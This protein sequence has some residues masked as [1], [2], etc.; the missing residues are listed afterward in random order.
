MISTAGDAALAV[1]ARD[2]AL[3][4][5][6]LQVER[7]VHQ[8]LRAALFGEEVDDAV[9]RLVGAVGVQR[10]E[11]QVAGFGERDRV[12]PSSRGR[13]SR[14]SGSRRAPGA[15]CSSAP[16]SQLSVSTPTSRCVMM[17]F[18]CVVHELDRV[19]DRDDVA[20]A[21]SR[22]GSR[23]S[24]RARSTCPSRWR[25]RRSRG[26]AWSSTTS[27]STGGRPQVVERRDV[28]RDRA[29][30]HADAGPAARSAL[31]RKRPM[32]GGADREVAFL[33]SRSNS[34]ACLSFMIARTSS[35]RVLR[36]QRLSATPA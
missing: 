23:P 33:A 30:H 26:R 25:R 28:G 24:P 27:L 31:T 12:A 10:R 8:Q 15:A 2:Q 16:L 18:L 3:R 29:Q 36:R 32:P 19:L 1:A 11:A 17:Q 35:Q 20:V 13:G 22:C 14:R 9:E 4:D 6:R 7:Q 5:E 21:C 34:A